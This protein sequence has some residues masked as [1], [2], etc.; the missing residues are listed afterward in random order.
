MQEPALHFRP[1]CKNSGS[2]ISISPKSLSATVSMSIRPEGQPTRSP[3]QSASR[4]RLPFRRIRSRAAGRT[5][6]RRDKSRRI[7][8]LPGLLKDLEEVVHRGV[9]GKLTVFEIPI[10][11][12]LPASIF[13]CASADRN[14]PPGVEGTAS[15]RPASA[16]LLSG[17]RPS[18]VPCPTTYFSASSIWFRVKNVPSRSLCL[19]V[20]GSK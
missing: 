13:T 15:R 6:S 17:E 19:G 1:D 14:R 5:W 10:G 11:E 18:M 8:H 20:F 4:H 9:P 7:S 3:L 2:D 16:P 12:G